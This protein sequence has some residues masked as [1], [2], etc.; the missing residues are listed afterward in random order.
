[1]VVVLDPFQTII[2]VGWPNYR[3]IAFRLSVRTV[4]NVVN[5]TEHC[6]PAVVGPGG[7]Y[8][9]DYVSGVTFEIMDNFADTIYVSRDGNHWVAPDDDFPVEIIGIPASPGPFSHGAWEYM[10]SRCGGR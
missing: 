3:Y 6:T 8:H 1:M 4:T 9:Y 7:N 5:D 2:E 10:W